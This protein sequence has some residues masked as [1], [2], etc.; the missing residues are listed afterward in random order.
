MPIIGTS[1]KRQNYHASSPR[2]HF[3]VDEISYPSSIYPAGETTHYVEEKNCM[4]AVNYENKKA[5]EECMRFTCLIL[6]REEDGSESPIDRSF[7]YV[8][9]FV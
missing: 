4:G 3:A 1:S 7:I 5:A 8:F 6:F 2:P 9:F